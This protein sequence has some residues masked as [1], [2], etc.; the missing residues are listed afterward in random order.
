MEKQDTAKVRIFPPGVP[1][2]TIL[3]GVGLQWL[4]PLDLGFV[5]PAQVRYWVGGLIIAAA[6]FGLGVWSVLLFK[7]GGQSPNPW[8]KTPSI[9][10]RGPYRITRNPMYLQ[11]VLICIGLAILLMNWW[12]L[13]FT[14]LVAWLLHRFAILPE[15]AYLEQKFGEEYLDYKKRVRRWI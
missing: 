13:I 6:F 12:I 7:K 5:I 2:V 3:L 1:L 14:P 11:M 4:W 9:E 15:E 8:K 10:N